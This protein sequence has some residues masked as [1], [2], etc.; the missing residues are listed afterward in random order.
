MFLTAAS[1]GVLYLG[2]KTGEAVEPRPDMYP[3]ASFRINDRV[4][5]NLRA[6]GVPEATLAK[7]DKYEEKESTLLWVYKYTSKKYVV[8]GKKFEPDKAAEETGQTRETGEQKLLAGL[9]TVLSEEEIAQHRE[10]ILRHAYLFRVS[11][12]WLIIGYM[13]ITLGELMLSPMG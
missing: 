4:I 12:L 10:K 3:N 6:E 5:A 7:L 11:P 1:F 2:A 9:R 13:V 8:K